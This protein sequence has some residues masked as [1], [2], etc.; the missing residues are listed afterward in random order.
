MQV[1]LAVQNYEHAH[2]FYP[3]GTIDKQGPIVNQ[4][5]GYHVG[6]IVQILPF[7]EQKNAHRQI[8]FSVGVYHANNKT[9]E[10][11]GIGVLHCPTDL[12]VAGIMG[13]PGVPSTSYAACHH[14]VEAPIDVDNNGVFF[15]NSRV[16]TQD[17]VDGLSF[18]IFA[19]E[20]VV[21]STNLGWMSGT[22]ATL[23][24]T[25]TPIN[26]IL[27][28]TG[29]GLIEPGVTD[30]AAGYLQAA[31]VAQTPGPPGTF[32]GGFSS[33]HPGGANFVLGDGSSR[34]ISEAITPAIY[35]RL[36]HRADGQLIGADD[37]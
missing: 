20:K 16:R 33:Y 3:A 30:P 9:V 4:P 11:H 7:L 10:N 34:F 26:A 18:T 25:G 24:N 31:G 6:W 22:R 29:S 27:S 17:V 14:D 2:L 1:G 37:F 12:N 15:L 5:N 21:D 36:G 23:R 35:Q 19:G 13:P 28:A 32:V 8:D